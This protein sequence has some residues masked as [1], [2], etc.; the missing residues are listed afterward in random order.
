VFKVGDKF[1]STVSSCFYPPGEQTLVIVDIHFDKG[2][3]GDT[4]T[5][6][7]RQTGVES[8]LFLTEYQ[9]NRRF[10]IDTPLN[11][12]LYCVEK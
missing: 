4:T 11:R 7:V 8:Y 9:I 3:H 6:Q 12:A 2:W 10:V 1:I 5:Y